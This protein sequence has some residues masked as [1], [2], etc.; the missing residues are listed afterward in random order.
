VLIQERI[1]LK[2]LL[3]RETEWYV[4]NSSHLS[5]NRILEESFS[6][7][8]FPLVASSTNDSGGAV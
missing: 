1:S 2:H 5:P 8:T 6:F 4:S 7:N 3:D